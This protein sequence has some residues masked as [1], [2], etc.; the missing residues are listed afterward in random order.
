MV[1]YRIEY[2]MKLIIMDLKN[3]I[4]LGSCYSDNYFV[5]SLLVDDR[6]RLNPENSPLSSISVKLFMGSI[7]FLEIAQY[8]NVSKNN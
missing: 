6:V 4:V 3:K 2:L 1:L 5:L 7:I 8:G